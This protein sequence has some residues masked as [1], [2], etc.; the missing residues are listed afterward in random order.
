MRNWSESLRNWSEGL[1]S[2]YA[3]DHLL[4][5]RS[6]S[7]EV[8]VEFTLAHASSRHSEERPSKASFPLSETVNLCCF[9]WS[10]QS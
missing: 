3:A 4:Y 7:F 8:N 2:G 5:L 1:A 10:K 9:S 6:A